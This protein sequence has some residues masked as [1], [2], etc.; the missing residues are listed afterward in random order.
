MAE[1]ATEECSE[2]F[3]MQSVT[4]KVQDSWVNAELCTT[5]GNIGRAGAARQEEG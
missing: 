5:L 4:V 2:L 3:S 1:E